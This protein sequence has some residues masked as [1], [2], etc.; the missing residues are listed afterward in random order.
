MERFED[1][2]RFAYLQ[3]HRWFN[4]LQGVRSFD[5]CA[6]LCLIGL[7]QAAK[8]Y[9]DGR[10]PFL[11]FAKTCIDNA[12]RMDLRSY[13]RWSKE[14]VSE[15][16][17]LQQP[18]MEPAILEDIRDILDKLPAATQMILRMYFWEGYSQREIALMVGMSRTC[19]SARVYRALTLM[20]REL[21]Y[22]RHS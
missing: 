4:R 14:I 18:P 2:Q 7:H 19:I 9:K 13:K 20:R 17:N 1:N 10:G 21:A 22:A 16:V 12:V 6:Q 15:T 11:P 8:H 3:A 5:E